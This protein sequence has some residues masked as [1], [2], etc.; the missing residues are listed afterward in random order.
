MSSD[1]LVNDAVLVT[2]FEGADPAIERVVDGLAECAGYARLVDLV[3]DLQAASDFAHVGDLL[4]AIQEG[5]P[6]LPSALVS[7]MAWEKLLNEFWA[8]LARENRFTEEELHRVFGCVGANRARFIHHLQW[9]AADPACHRVL[10]S[11]SKNP[12]RPIPGVEVLRYA[13]PERPP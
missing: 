13:P 11:R 12:P 1:E 3:R 5:A 8:L 9:L 6:I 4:A 7:D 10:Q 2:F